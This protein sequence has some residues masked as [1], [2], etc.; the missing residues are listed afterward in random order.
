MVCISGRSSRELVLLEELG[1]SSWRPEQKYD[2]FFLIKFE[3]YNLNF[4]VIKALDPDP[5]SS[6]NLDESRSGS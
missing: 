2:A 1:N 3:F 6:K 5:D 4:L